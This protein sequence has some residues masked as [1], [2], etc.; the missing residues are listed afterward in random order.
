MDNEKPRVIDNDRDEISV[1]LNGKELRGWNY[2]SDDERR[3]KMLMA[4]EYVEGYCDGNRLEKV[5]LPE[6]VTIAPF[7]P[8]AY[9]DK[10]MDCIRVLTHNRSVTEHRIDG[11]FTVFECNHRG[12][13]DP[14]YVGFSIKGVRHL[15]SEI[16]LPLEGVYALAEIIRRIITH[17]PG[18]AMSELLRIIFKDYESA[19]DL[20]VDLDPIIQ[21]LQVRLPVSGSV[22]PE[23]ERKLWLNL[24]E[25]SFK[26][27]YKDKE[28]AN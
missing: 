27:I 2:A 24:L 19:G 20:K 5:S 13:F 23:E 22:W 10:H 7:S 11:M 21:G 8:V 26:L 4:R 16:G 3:Q 15:F 9:Y 25:G 14:E 12:E 18:S 17:K 28:A 6:G 1:S